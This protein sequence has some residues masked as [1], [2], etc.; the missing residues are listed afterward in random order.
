[1]AANSSHGTRSH[2]TN[3]THALTQTSISLISDPTSLDD[4]AEGSTVFTAKGIICL[5]TVGYR[6]STSRLKAS[7]QSTTDSEYSDLS[8]RV[9]LC[10]L[11]TECCVRIPNLIFFNMTVFLSSTLMVTQREYYHASTLLVGLVQ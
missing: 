9:Q 6:R 5:F 10:R 11:V 8:V 1:M 4:L 7:M 2:N 3:S